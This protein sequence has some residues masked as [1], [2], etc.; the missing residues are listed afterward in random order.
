MTFHRT[1]YFDKNYH[2][3]EASSA[4]GLEQKV[5][6]AIELGYEPVGSLSHIPSNLGGI[7]EDY[8]PAEYKQA[9]KKVAP[10]TRRGTG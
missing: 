8:S 5:N 10:K 4:A 2:V 7:F 6:E 3:L 9:I 1:V